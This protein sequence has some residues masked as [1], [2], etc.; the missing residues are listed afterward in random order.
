MASYALEKQIVVDPEGKRLI[1]AKNDD[2]G[3]CIFFEEDASKTVWLTV[4][5]W[6]EVNRVVNIEILEI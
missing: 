6:V 4:G 5:E 3:L 1:M 2:G